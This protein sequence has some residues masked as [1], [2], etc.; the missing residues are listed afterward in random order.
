MRHQK[1][2][3][4]TELIVVIA[5]IGVLAGIVIV[6]YNGV[7]SRAY[8]AAVQA[9]LESFA[10]L[11]EH[12]RVYDSTNTARE[13]PRTTA[14]LATLGIKASKSSY[15]TSVNYNFIYC[16]ANSGGNAY[17][18]YRLITLSKSGTI[19][20]MTQD[21]LVS[22]SLTAASLTATVC[23]TVYSMSLISNGLSAP[24]T[25]QSWVGG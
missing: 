19:F 20:V 1:G 5:S 12:Y 18:D 10:G 15:N 23:T 4:L 21:G 22:H 11:L 8:D 17:K 13:Y 16:L 24:N 3:S 7:Q 25:W 14:T 6:A 9:D 2:F